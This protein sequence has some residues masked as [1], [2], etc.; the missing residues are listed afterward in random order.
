MK[1]KKV[2][3]AVLAA[4]MVMAS[5]TTVC[6]SGYYSSSSSSA[7]E[8]SERSLP[9][10]AESVKSS[11][12]AVQV[13]GIAVRTSVSGA[14]A[15]KSVQGTAVITPLSDVKAKLGLTG[16][17]QPAITIYDTDAK[18]S[19]KAL[20]CI[21]A[22]ADALGAEVLTSLNIDLGA[23]ENGRWVALSDGSVALAAG[24]P[25]DADTTKT[26]VA[27]CVQPGGAVTILEDQDTN[28]RTVTFEVKAGIGT[29]A[30]AAQ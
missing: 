17:Q 14:Y 1:F 11:N 19:P 24:L 20:A 23:K 26:Y 2:L 5:A 4:T 21:D 8:D 16:A 7:S 30:I 22:A 27:I 25:E 9:E 18:K 12:E 28:P 13:A 29:Y 10:F 15:A 6:A 3:A